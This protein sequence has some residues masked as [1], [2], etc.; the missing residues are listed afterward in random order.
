MS[1]NEQDLS[2]RRNAFQFLTQHDQQRA[3][4]YLLGQVLFPKP[5]CSP[6]VRSWFSSSCCANG[7]EC[8]ASTYVFLGAAGGQRGAV[9]WPLAAGSIGP[10]T[11][12]LLQYSILAVSLPG[13][14]AILMQGANANA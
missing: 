1:Q 14:I 6:V 8:T 10:H 7:A 2:T 13:D 9:G 3:I 12:G 11:K 5:A 4:N